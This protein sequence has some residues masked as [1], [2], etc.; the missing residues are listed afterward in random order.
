MNTKP[1]INSTTELPP[2]VAAYLDAGP[3]TESAAI[4]ELFTTNAVVV[5]DGHTYRG[6]AEII[7]WRADIARSFTY[8]TTRL[9]TERGD[10]TIVVVD[11]IEGNFP[12]GRVDIT[13]RFTLDTTH[14]IDSLT[15]APVPVSRS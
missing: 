11:R 7:A 15:I 12:G 1:T 6:R 10:N 8:T 9:R 13:S 14:R 4:G 3:D 5:D 2:A